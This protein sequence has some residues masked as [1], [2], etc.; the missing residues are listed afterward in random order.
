M[1][2]AYFHKFLF[3]KYDLLNEKKSDKII[4]TANPA[5]TPTISNKSVQLVG[6]PLNIIN[7]NK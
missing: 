3:F 6:I 7:I 5:A 1:K 2:N 4:K